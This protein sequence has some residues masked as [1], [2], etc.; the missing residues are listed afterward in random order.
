MRRWLLL[1][2]TAASVAGC[3]GG[4]DGV[5]AREGCEDIWTSVCTRY[6]E[7]YRPDEIAEIGLPP[8]A[9]GCAEMLVDDNCGSFTDTA[10]GDGSRYHPSEVLPCTNAIL[11]LECPLIADAPTSVPSCD[12]VCAD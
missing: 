7:C 5:S 11:A 9:A 12:P 1:V 4:F 8:T 2:A 3:G 10:C 6:Y